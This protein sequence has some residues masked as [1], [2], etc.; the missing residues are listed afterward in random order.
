MATQGVPYISHA[1]AD[2]LVSA[3]MRKLNGFSRLPNPLTKMPQ[4]LPRLYIYNV[5]EQTY[6]TPMTAMHDGT[7]SLPPIVR[8]P[9]CKPGQ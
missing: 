4:N 6:E 1:L 8:I 2:R 9:A 3:A 5:S 7:S